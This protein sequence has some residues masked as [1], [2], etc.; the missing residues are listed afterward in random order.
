MLCVSNSIQHKNFRVKLLLNTVTEP[1]KTEGLLLKTFTDKLLTRGLLQAR[2]GRLRRRAG[3]GTLQTL[4][5][6]SGVSRHMARASAI[7]W[8]PVVYTGYMH[9]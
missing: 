3:A 2:A 1:L 7:G 5:T 9:G 4:G 6:R 8:S